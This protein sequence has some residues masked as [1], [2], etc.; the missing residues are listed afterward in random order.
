MRILPSLLAA[1]FSNLSKSVGAVEGC[2]IGGLHCDV[3]DGHFVPN[4]TFGPMVVEAVRRVTSLPLYVHLMIEQPERYLEQFV[5]AGASSIT[6]HSEACPHLHRVVQQIKSLGVMA[7]VALNPST[8]LCAIE[9]V[10]PDIDLA[11]VMTVNPGFGGQSFI[12]TMLPKIE[13]LRRMAEESGLDL[14]IAVDGG[15]DVNTAPLVVTAGANLLIAGTSLFGNDVP[16][17]EA[18]TELQRA[19][20]AGPGS[21]RNN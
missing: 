11:L 21:R 7:G 1:D 8:P 12:E 5:S 14:D 15:I 10:L 3:M 4:I 17:G 20:L 6:V 2:D 13:R 19:A 16:A 9:H 18:C